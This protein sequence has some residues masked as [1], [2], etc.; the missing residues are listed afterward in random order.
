MIL[1]GNSIPFI[2]LLELEKINM[3]QFQKTE[4]KLE[5][6]TSSDQSS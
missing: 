5:K 2:H 1:V 3:E 6:T 4:Q